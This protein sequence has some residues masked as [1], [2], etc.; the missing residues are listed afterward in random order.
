MLKALRLL[1]A[2]LVVAGIG[3]ATTA[4]ASQIYGSQ[5]GSYRQVDR[6]AY[7]QGYREGLKD[8]EN[9]VRRGRNYAYASHSTYRDADE[10][11]RRSDGNLDQ[12]RRT[13]RQGYQTGYNESFSRYGANNGRSS[14]GTIYPTYPTYPAYPG[15]SYPNGSA[16]PRG[17]YSSPAGDSG[18][19]DGL[20][21]GRN[22]ARDR[23]RY[24]PVRA[25]RYRE[26]D[27]NYN[28]RYGSREQYKRDYRAAFE[29]G[30]REGYQQ[31][32]Y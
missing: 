26:G 16:V 18:Y 12:Y 23:D 13:F 20:E 6:R 15:P 1:P 25:K 31:N 17:A 11:Y 3:I 29:Q 32:R 14:R 28:S 8:G 24:D 7:D 2:A 4:C 19:R 10:G 5:G 21:A 9:D 22:A 30:Y 27:H